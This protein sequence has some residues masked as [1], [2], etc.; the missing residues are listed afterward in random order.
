MTQLYPD[1]GYSFKVELA[2]DQ[3]LQGMEIGDDVRTWVFMSQPASLV[4]AVRV[5]HQLESARKA[6]QSAS[7]SGRKKSLNV[8]NPSSAG[9]DKIST[10]IRE[11]RELV[12][13]MNEKIQD[14]EKKSDSKATANNPCKMPGGTKTL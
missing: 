10:E 11:L 1:A 9:D 7:T 6:C 8:V 2:K 5:V 12:L 3:F 13:G 4:E 14:L